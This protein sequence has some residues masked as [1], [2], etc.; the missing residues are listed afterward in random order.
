MRHLHEPDTDCKR[1]AT[2]VANIAIAIITRHLRRWLDGGMAA[3]ARSELE[4]YLEYEFHDAAADCGE[5]QTIGDAARRVV[6]L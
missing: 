2:R 4:A 3:G 5:W 6:R 1:R